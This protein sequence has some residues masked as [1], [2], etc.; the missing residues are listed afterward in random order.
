MAMLAGFFG[1]LA[2]LLA[3]VGL[4]GM[5]SFAVAQRR[6]EIGIR[7]ALGADRRR[8][9]RDGDAR[10]R[11]AARWSGSW[12]A[13]GW[14]LAAARSAA[15]LLFGLIAA[16][17]GRRM[18]GACLLLAVIAGAASFLPARRAARLDPLTALRLD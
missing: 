11:L 5:M 16:R 12:S 1:A 3:M 6:Q 14:L 10:R 15:S 8:H 4:Y 18:A 9:R 13:A 17:P 7:V 2:A